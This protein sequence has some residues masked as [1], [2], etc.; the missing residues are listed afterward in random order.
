[1]IVVVLAL[2]PAAVAV[3]E[4]HRPG[5]FY[6]YVVAPI[7]DVQLFYTSDADVVALRQRMVAAADE[8]LTQTGVDR[9]SWPEIQLFDN[10]RFAR[11]TPI[12]TLDVRVR[13]D[14]PMSTVADS[15]RVLCSTLSDSELEIRIVLIK[16]ENV[17][18]VRPE[19]NAGG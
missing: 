3:D 17:M 6:R 8:L 7:P 2:V 14:V 19:K 12:G 15:A 16:G 18:E 10:K 4:Q 1:M 13:P 11:A 9:V 5:L